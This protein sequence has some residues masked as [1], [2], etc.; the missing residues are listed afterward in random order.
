MGGVRHR[1]GASSVQ[2]LWWNCGNPDCD[3]KGACQVKKSEAL[4]TEAR[5]GDGPT[6]MSDEVSVM[7]AERRGRVVLV[8]S[9]VNFF[10][11]MN[12]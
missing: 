2:A 6:R 4:S 3:A 7:D 11:R 10:G 9:V 12:C 5:F 8:T 1:D